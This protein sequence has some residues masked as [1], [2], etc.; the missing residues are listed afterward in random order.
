MDGG[1]KGGFEGPGG[2]T[3][4]PSAGTDAAET[5]GVRRWP[6]GWILALAGLLTTV[7]LLLSSCGGE[8]GSAGSGQGAAR[9][10]EE[11]QSGRLR[12]GRRGPLDLPGERGAGRLGQ[13]GSA[14]GARR[15]DD[16][17]VT[18]AATRAYPGAK[19]RE[20]G[21][22]SKRTWREVGAG[23]TVLDGRAAPRTEGDS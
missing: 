10:G 16:Q 5:D 7:T 18:W 15:R 12:G 23:G 4:G 9:S 8:A 20:M 3:G 19:G 2:A 6:V 13:R 22:G 11:T 14:V 17:P 21:E 1:R